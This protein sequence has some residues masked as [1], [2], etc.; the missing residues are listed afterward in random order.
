MIEVE[1]LLE[2]KIVTIKDGS[3]GEREYI[4]SK[5]PCWQ[6]QKIMELLPSS[7]IMNLIPKLANT[8]VSDAVR[9]EMMSYAAV[10]VGNGCITRFTTQQFIEQQV[11]DW[12]ALTKLQAE[13]LMY[14]ASFLQDGQILNFLVECAQTHIPKIIEILM[15]S[16][17]Q[18][19]PAGEQPSTS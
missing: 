2:P 14:N 8:K 12:E 10:D 3:G 19:S 7:A 18:S 1:G 9:M 17:E 4:I 16:L 5:F 11:K 15:A 13:I 6:G